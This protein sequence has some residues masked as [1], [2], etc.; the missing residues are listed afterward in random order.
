M[1]DDE[2]GAGTGRAPGHSEV[3]VDQNLPSLPQGGV[4]EVHNVIHML[5]DIC[6]VDIHKLQTF[7]FYSDRFVIILMNYSF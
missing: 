1:P 4:N 3:A 2:V 7:I 5:C 6:L